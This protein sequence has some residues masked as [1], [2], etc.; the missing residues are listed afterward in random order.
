MRLNPKALG[1]TSGIL[2]GLMVFLTTIWLLIIGAPGKTISLLSSF[3]FGYSFSWGG[4]FIG[5]FWGFIDGLICGFIFAWLY[6]ILLPKKA[7]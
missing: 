1:L 7:E 4:A 5:L 6:N 2:W 3:Y